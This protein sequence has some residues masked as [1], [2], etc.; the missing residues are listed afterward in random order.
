MGPR[1][2]SKLHSNPSTRC[3][4]YGTS[5]IVLSQR[6]RYQ[7]N[8]SRLTVTGMSANGQQSVQQWPQTSK[9]GCKQAKQVASLVCQLVAKPVGSSSKQCKQVQ[10]FFSW[11]CMVAQN[12]DKE[13]LATVTKN[14]KEAKQSGKIGYRLPVL[15][16]RLKL[17]LHH[18]P[19]W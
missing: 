4:Q 2:R 8:T 13:G 18:S 11:H 6:L 17:P 14:R 12:N 19:N 5:S 10:A 9:T 16:P 3:K 15:Q 1:H 7:H